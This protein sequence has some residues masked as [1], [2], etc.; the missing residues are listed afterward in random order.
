MSV[1]TEIRVPLKHLHL[2]ERWAKDASNESRATK[3][4]AIL[5]A[6]RGERLI[7]E[8]ARQLEVHPRSIT[9]WVERYKDLGPQGL[10]RVTPAP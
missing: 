1:S 7:G 5:E 8:I 3:A 6:A 2:L 9:R 10:L 4:R